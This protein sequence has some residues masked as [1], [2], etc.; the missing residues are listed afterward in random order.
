MKLFTNKV[1]QWYT[2]FVEVK[3]PYQFEFQSMKDIYLHSEFAETLLVKGNNK[4]I[5]ILSGVAI[6]LLII[7]CFNFINLTTART[8]YRMKETGV[9]KILGA[10]RRQLILQ[11][12]I[13][14]ALF[15]VI[16]TVLSVFIYQLAIPV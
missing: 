10:G 11:F 13:E 14:S 9:R 16:A 2:G 7:A 8:I 4:N 6:L 5:F 1:N 3:N 15:F 12:L